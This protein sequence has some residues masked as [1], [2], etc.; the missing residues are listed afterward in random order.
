[1]LNNIR[2][3]DAQLS[4]NDIRQLENADQLAH[5]LARLGYNVDGRIAIPDP[6]ALG[7]SNEDVRQHIHKIELLGEDPVDGDIIIYLFEVRAV[8]AKLRNE[9]ARRFRDRPEKALLVLTTN[10]EEL[11]WVML[12]R[13]EERSRSK[14]QPL[15]LAIRPVPFTVNRLNPTEIARRVLQRFTFT[16]EDADY[17]W[18]KLRSAYMLAEWSEEYFNNR[19]LFS[20]YYLQQRLTDPKL[21]PE[22]NADVRPVGRAVLEHMTQARKAFGGQGE[23]QIRARLYEPL[24]ALLG[25]DAVEG[26]AGSSA[27]QE[28]DYLLYAPGERTKPL[29]AALVY[30]WNRNLDDVDPQRDPETPDEIPGAAVVSVLEGMP[31]MASPQWRPH[32]G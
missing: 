28:P 13:S 21:T 7:L 10:Y 17:Q 8:T 30:V 3:N 1:M 12:Q 31:Y 24:F 29:A 23:Q 5:F 32:S 9:I 15:K 25:F 16:E 20:D 22:W 18:D 14:F 27:A 26:K 4:A 11:E 19:A 6:A 2:R